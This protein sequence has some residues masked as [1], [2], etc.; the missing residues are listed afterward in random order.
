M[1]TEAP[2]DVFEFCVGT[3]NARG[4]QQG[5]SGLRRDLLEIAYHHSWSTRQIGKRLACCDQ[6]QP[7]RLTSQTSQKVFEGW[8]AQLAAFKFV[9]RLQRFH[10]IEH[11]QSA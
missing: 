8:I 11:E 1:W 7:V 10:A 6:A 9:R 4:A 3:D 5:A 2:R